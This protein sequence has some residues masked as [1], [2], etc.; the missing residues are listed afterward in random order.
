MIEPIIVEFHVRSPV[1][2]AFSMWTERAAL[3]WPSSH[4][5]SKDDALDIVFEPEVG[6]RIYERPSSGP[7]HEWGEIVEWNPPDS[8]SYL[9]FVF[10]D[11]SNATDVTVSFN[12][13]ADG[14]LVR[15]TQG[16]FDRLG[17]A[18]T[19]RRQRTMMAWETLSSIY[20]EAV[21]RAEL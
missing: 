3:W 11:K 7:E 4:T 19:E 2:H 13:V 8:L 15:I 1:S 18:G 5:V 14:T 21:A 12:E 16:G 20:A 17:V 9:W 10:F 6:G